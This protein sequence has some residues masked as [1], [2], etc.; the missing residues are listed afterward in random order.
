[1]QEP[2]LK[3]DE[4]LRIQEESLLNFRFALSHPPPD[5]RIG[6]LKTIRYCLAYLYWIT[7]DHYGAAVLGEFIA[8]TY[9]DSPEGQ[10]GAKIALASYAKLSSEAATRDDQKFH[11]RHMENIARHA[12]ERWPGSRGAD[13]AWMVLVRSA[14][15]DRQLKKAVE[16]LDEVPADSPR[17][18]EAELAAGQALWAA[19]LD[20]LRLS[21]EER[22]AK[23]DMNRMLVEAKK[24]LEDGIRRLRKPVDDGGKVDYNLAAAV[25]SLAQI[26]LD[27]GQAGQAVRW[28][29]DPKIGPHT[30]LNDPV[31]DRG[32]FRVETIK[33]TLRAYVAVRNLE[34][35]EKAMDALEKASGNANLTRIYISLGRQLEDSLKRIRAEGKKDEAAE[36]ARGFELFL[37]RL[38]SRPA[39]ETTFNSLSWVAETFM[40]LGGSLE[41]GRDGALSPEAEGFYRKAADAYRRIL[42]LCR[43]D[44]K[45]SP[46]PGAEIGVQVRLARCLRY[47]GRFDEALDTLVEI[48]KVRNTLVDAQREAATTYEAW[49]AVKA[50]YYLLA[51]KGGHKVEQK[52]GTVTYLV[53]GWADLARRVQANADYES[54]FHEARYH[55]ALCRYKLAPSKNGQERSDLLK[56]AETDITL[57]FQLD[58]EMGGR[59][60]YDQYDALLRKIQKLRGEKKDQEMGLKGAA[61]AA[62]E[63]KRS[64]SR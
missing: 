26:Y 60:W 15:A 13:E 10:Q 31:T 33:A 20:A 21:D 28:I 16:Y 58:P 61:A 9:P 30:L 54:L 11:N 43:A 59:A 3:P 14:V 17:R 37:S 44:D 55:L 51:I 48:L 12:T 49:G 23:A 22:P 34:A 57:V 7:N 35:A 1:M 53:W 45:F 32:N 24:A 2:D 56:H 63:N 19:Y 46:Q 52:D 50:G 40:S 36:V 29:D 27:V 39:A 18:G 5:I 41:S 6:E 42:E 8:R 62:A 47:L 4:L 25:L 38:S 64:S